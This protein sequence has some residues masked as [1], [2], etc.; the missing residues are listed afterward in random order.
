MP[1]DGKIRQSA[2]GVF[3]SGLVEED[4]VS[5][6]ALIGKALLYSTLQSLDLAARS[7]EPMICGFYLSLRLLHG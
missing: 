2:S 7:L 4:Y 3:M 1:D 5:V 6:E